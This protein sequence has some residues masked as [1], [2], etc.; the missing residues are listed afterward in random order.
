MAQVLK[1]EEAVPVLVRTL[2]SRYDAAVPEKGLFSD[3]VA[4][5]RV[6]HRSSLNGSESEVFLEM[7]VRAMNPD[8]DARFDRL[9]FVALRARSPET[10]GFLSSTMFHGTKGELRSVLRRLLDDPAELLEAATALLEG[11]PEE[12]DPDLWR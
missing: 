7:A 1:L 3:L 11:L 12:S 10:Q 9:R 2:L 6:H 8:A 5:E 4:V